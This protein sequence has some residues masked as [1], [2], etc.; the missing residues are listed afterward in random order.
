MTASSQTNSQH[1]PLGGRLNFQA[2]INSQGVT[3]QIGGWAALT[4]DQD[5]YLQ[6]KFGQIFQ[7]TGVATQGRADAAQWVKSYKLEY[8]TD[9]SSWTLYP[10]VRCTFKILLMMIYK[11]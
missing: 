5:Q 11:G 9:G 10:D 6:I 7:I 4:N 3:T 1:E 8:S 2:Q